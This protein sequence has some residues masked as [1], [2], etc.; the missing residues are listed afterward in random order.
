MGFPKKISQLPSSVSVK[1]T[2]LFVTVND[3]D[4]TT[5]ATIGQLINLVS[6]STNTYV[7]GGTY[8]D[9]TKNIDFDGNSGFPPFSVN[10]S[11]ISTT[12]TFVTGATLNG[13]TLEI[14]RNN[15]EP[16]I[17]VDLSSLTGDTDTNTFITGTTLVGSEYTIT[18]NNGTDFTTDFNPIVSGKLDTNIF[19][20]Y[21]ANTTDNVVT[22]ATLVGTTLELER[23]NGL[24]DVTV[25]L[26]PL[27][28]ISEN[29][30]VTGFTYN[31]DNTLTISRNDGVDLSASINTMTGLTVN[32]NLLLPDGGV[33][34]PY[35]GL[36]DAE[37]LKIFHNGN[38]SIIRETGT[39]SLYLQSDDSVILSKD[40]GTELM[41]RGIAD[42]SVELYYD[43]VK[44]L[45]T[46]IDG[47][48]L[49]GD[50]ITG[51]N[52]LTY[53]PTSAGIVS[54]LDF[55]VTQFGQNNNT[56][57]SSVKSI[58]LFLD[59]NGGDSGQAFRIYNNA[60]PDS[61]PLE[62]TYIFKVDESGDVLI[63]GNLSLLQTPTLN[64]SGTDIL[65]RNNVTGEVEY[66]PVSG[67]TPTDNNTFVTGGTYNNG[68]T[69][70]DFV[71]NSGFTPFSVNVQSLIS[72]FEVTGTQ[73]AVQPKDSSYTNTTQGTVWLGG[74]VSKIAGDYNFIGNGINHNIEAAADYSF[75]GNGNN[76]H[77]GDGVNQVSYSAILAGKDN[78]IEGTVSNSAIIAGE[79]NTI[80]HNNTFILG[81]NIN[82]SQANTTYVENLNIGDVGSAPSVI[83]LGLDANGNVVTGVT[84]IDTNT[85][86]TG[87]T[88]TNDILDIER[89]DGVGISVDLSSIDTNIF[90]NSGNADVA[91]QQL[92]FTN[93][94]GGTFNVT[95]AAAL[96]TDNDINVTGGTYDNN[97]GCVTFVTNSGTSFDICGFITG[98]TD[99]Y[100]D[101]ASLV[102]TTYTLN[103]TDGV[104][105]PTDFNPI[106]S[107]KLDTDIFNT[108][109]ANTTD[110]VVT[111][112]TLN[113]TILELERNNGLTDV[114]VDLSSLTG[115]VDTNTFVTG[116]TLTNTTLDITRND[117]VNIPV[118]LGSL[119]FTGNTSGTCI[120][121][122]WVSNI[123]GCSPVTIGTELV[124]NDDTSIN[125][126]LTVT[127]SGSNTSDTVFLVQDSLGNHIIEGLDSGQVHVGDLVNSASPS[128]P[129]LMIGAGKTPNDRGSLA[130]TSTGIGIGGDNDATGDYLFFQLPGNDE[131]R[132]RLES[133]AQFGFTLVSRQNNNFGS[134][135]GLRSSFYTSRTYGVDF[136][137]GYNSGLAVTDT[138]GYRFN[139]KDNT[140]AGANDVE[141]FVIENGASETKSYFDNISVLGVGTS[142]PDTN[143]RLHITGDTLFNGNLVQ[144]NCTASGDN[145]VAFGNGTTASG[146]DTLSIGYETFA[147]GSNSFAGGRGSISNGQI[148][149]SFGLNNIVSGNRSVVIGGEE[150]TGTTDDNVE[151]GTH[152][153]IKRGTLGNTIISSGCKIGSYNN[154]GH[155]TFMGN[156]CLITVRCLLCGSSQL[157]NNVMMGTQ[158]VVKENVKIPDN[159]TI[160]GMAFVNKNFKSKGK[161]L[162][163]IPAKMII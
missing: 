34:G 84:A 160:G 127:S 104:T 100:I 58:N 148:S 9:I 53:A 116:A 122:L 52:R 43:N 121:E 25:D 97:T 69:S 77:L 73:G 85:F 17:T 81:S 40:S 163:G 94:S 141:R 142:N 30:F 68:T 39:G 56:V 27:S 36:G 152:C 57:L 108:Y 98:L 16:Q 124:V 161:K 74:T 29:T 13:L 63:K 88:L 23:N 150:I 123:S 114:T 54:F 101:N 87:A 162:I 125:G 44:K 135:S 11:G 153:D 83:N 31:D 38:H 78:T 41:V 79:N 102:G 19:N 106:V 91:L 120:N 146:S 119:T 118:N 50:L 51:D 95:N 76:N 62:N 64:N 46:S 140:I 103:R 158:S 109:T 21:T 137:L 33:G 32:G 18:Q 28:G 45:E 22:G 75:I 151:I 67:I 70:L 157:G 49:S 12:D 2:D 48:V 138:V 89:N 60:S 61:P 115:A 65:I 156:N 24:S 131:S 143:F 99:T 107:G 7:T 6:G 10:L 14:D 145:S 35:I 134:G 4:I 90:V 20:T 149:F 111:G 129:T 66:R 155:N 112:A 59:S 93:T 154:I 86:V 139:T 71:G 133:T 117:G 8:N 42:G 5:K 132:W 126:H 96:F 47:V 105:I 15:G 113:G 159:T 1:L 26:S 72:P 82:S 136:L 80:T 128:S 130:F 147:G 110:N 55:T 144:N 37:D 92:T 3:S